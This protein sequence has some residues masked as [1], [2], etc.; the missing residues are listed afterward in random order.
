M[1]MR[2]VT[3]SSLFPNPEQPC[4]GLF[5]AE[6]LRQ[7][8][9]GGAVQARVV[10]PVPWFPGKHPRF[11]KYAEF[12]K[13]PAQST[14]EGLTVLHPKHA[15]IPGPGWYL[16]PR[17]MALAAAA[18]L[19]RLRAEGFDFEMIDAHYYFPDGV[20]A[21]LLGKWFKRPVVITALGTDVN[22]IPRYDLARRMV[23]NTS[24]AAAHSVA[25]SAALKDA[26][27]AIGIAEQSVSV[28][29][30][31]VDLTRFR[32]LDRA[33]L[34]QQLG[35]ERPTLLSAGNLIELK[36]HHLVIEALERLPEWQLVIAGKGALDAD[37]KGQVAERG[38]EDRVRFTGALSQHHLI[39]YYNAADALVL[40]SSREGM[41]NVVLEAM[42]CGL[43][44]VATCVGG[45]PEVLNARVGRLITERSALAIAAAVSSL[46]DDMPKRSLVRCHAEQFNWEAPIRGQL[47]LW[48]AT[49]KTLHRQ[50]DA[51]RDR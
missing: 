51:A 7:A 21:A 43:P 30:N 17:S 39:E 37:L 28:L 16:T 41:P 48:A 36:G 35:L 38:L 18:A 44:V 15:V 23:V 27:V 49:I 6:R 45:I 50:A 34:R 11:G 2:V 1:S 4:H 29:R 26:M 47:E 42:A 33:A 19:R 13:V 24:Q 20:A 40:A 46:A 25:V 3:F 31:G 32:L 8:M 12:A 10:A 14:W 5:V 9:K 22:V